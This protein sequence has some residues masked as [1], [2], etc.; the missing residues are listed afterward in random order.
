MVLQEWTQITVD[1]DRSQVMGAVAS[2][3]AS[4]SGYGE[5]PPAFSSPHSFINTS[6][7]ALLPPVP[8]HKPGGRLNVWSAM[9]PKS[10]TVGGSYAQCV[11]AVSLLIALPPL[12]PRS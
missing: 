8:S 5:T 4:A 1:D 9:D 2:T 6:V 3:L 10:V 12:T 11:T 7:G